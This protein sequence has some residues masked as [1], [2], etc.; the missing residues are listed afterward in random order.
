MVIKRYINA[1]RAGMM[2]KQDYVKQVVKK[3]ICPQDKKADIERQLLSDIEIA[4]GEGRQLEEILDEMGEPEALAKEFNDNFGG[5]SKPQGKRRMVI[6]VILV[7]AL[8]LAALAGLAYWALPKQ[9]DIGDS[10]KFTA[11]VVEQYST[12]V[13]GAF[14]RGD[15]DT[16]ESYYSKEMQEAVTRQMLEDFKPV[17]GDDWGEYRGVGTA[18]MAEVNQRGKAYVLVQLNATYENVSVTYTLTF[19][20]EMQLVGFYMK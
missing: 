11:Y 14:S 18:Y 4:L 1:E 19:N 6:T 16:L 8:V 2:T 20:S 3:L 5:S 13:V 12:E 17:I 9:R 10:G 7:V 15:Y